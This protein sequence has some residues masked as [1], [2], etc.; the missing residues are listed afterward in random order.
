MTS[1]ST[2]L[3]GRTFD[4]DGEPLVL[5]TESSPDEF[6]VIARDHLGHEVGFARAR[7]HRGDA[8]ARL[9][10]RTASSFRRRGL[11]RELLGTMLRWAEQ[12]GVEYLV[13]SAPAADV[14]V[15]QFLAGAGRPVA[16][17]TAGRTA[18]FSIAAPRR[19]AEPDEGDLVA[20]ALEAGAS[21]PEADALRHHRG[22][23][24][25]RAA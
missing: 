11:G 23:R 7:H 13:G 17:R 2:K 9:T 21:L 6:A 20:V 24:P 16:A 3:Q 1:R 18:T 15:R 8:A 19:S 4:V 5:W 12:E 10:L 25:S 22:G 14:G